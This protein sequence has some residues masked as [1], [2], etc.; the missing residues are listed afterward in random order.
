[1]PARWA[2]SSLRFRRFG[3]TVTLIEM[4]P[5]VV[6]LEDEEISA[7]LG[8]VMAK[9]WPSTP[10]PSTASRARDL[11]RRGGG[12]RAAAGGR[13]TDDRGHP[14]RGGRAG[15]VTDGVRLERTR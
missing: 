12:R 5:R 7:E 9:T 14:P 10:G 6:P 15:L 4:L 11:Q 1:M 8:K 3:S 2:S 13:T